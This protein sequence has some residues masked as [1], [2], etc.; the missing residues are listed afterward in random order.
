MF[1]LKISQKSRAEWAYQKEGEWIV[2]DKKILDEQEVP[3]GIEKLIGF[4]GRPDP[5]SGYYCLYNEG[6]LV[7]GESEVRQPSKISL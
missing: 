4:A 6:R 3:N 7:S 2:V 5:S 1:P